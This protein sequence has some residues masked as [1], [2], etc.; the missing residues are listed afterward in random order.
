MAKKRL[1]RQ[2]QP[3]TGWPTTLEVSNF[4]D[5]KPVSEYRQEQQQRQQ[6]QQQKQQQSNT[7]NIPQTG[8]DHRLGSRRTPGGAVLFSAPWA[9][10]PG[11]CLEKLSAI[12]PT[13]RTRRRTSESIVVETHEFSDCTLEPRIQM[14]SR[15]AVFVT[16]CGGGAILSSFL[17]GGGC[18]QGRTGRSS[19]T[20]LP[21][22]TSTGSRQRFPTCCC[23]CCCYCC[24]C[25]CR[26]YGYCR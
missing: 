10:P 9:D 26:Q 4:L 25:Y 18:R 16:I 12:A 20:T 22:R 2:P 6:Q 3:R 8:I 5:P 23:C 21:I 19:S 7:Q 13:T 1:S 24:C 11:P 17:P 15:T 14:A